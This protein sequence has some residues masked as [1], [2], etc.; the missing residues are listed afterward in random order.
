M[1][2]VFGGDMDL[3]S[4]EKMARF[5]RQMM[6]DFLKKNFEKTIS[7]P[8]DNEIVTR[9]KSRFSNIVKHI[10]EGDCYFLSPMAMTVGKPDFSKLESQKVEDIINTLSEPREMLYKTLKSLNSNMNQQMPGLDMTPGLAYSGLIVHDAYHF[11]QMQ[12]LVET[13]KK[14]SLQS[15]IIFDEDEQ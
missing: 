10:Y 2:E 1:A 4:P 11:G 8:G 7:K 14:K 13:I 6:V 9:A 15:E 12:L 5:S 3:D